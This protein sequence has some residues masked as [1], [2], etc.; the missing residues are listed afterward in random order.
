M[1]LYVEKCL[2]EVGPVHFKNRVPTEICWS[3]GF[4][5]SP[6]RTALK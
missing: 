4:D 2:R 1:Q 5:D 6:F 3:A